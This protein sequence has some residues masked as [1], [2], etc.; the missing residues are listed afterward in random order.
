MLHCRS[1]L[2][3]LLYLYTHTKNAGETTCERFLSCLLPFVFLLCL[4]HNIIIVRFKDSFVLLLLLWM[5]NN[6]VETFMDLWASLAISRN[7]IFPFAFH[8]IP[9]P[10]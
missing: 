9:L 7:I 8:F 2:C 10:L 3:E 4:E 1:L 5:M 6:F